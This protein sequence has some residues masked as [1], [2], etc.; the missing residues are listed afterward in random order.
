[1]M[2]YSISLSLQLLAVVIWMVAAPNNAVTSFCFVP[3]THGSHFTSRTSIKAGGDQD[4]PD[5]VAK[6]IIVTGD[7]QGGYYRSCV[8]NE[9]SFYIQN[10][11]CFSI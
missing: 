2:K 6:R 10:C 9:V 1:M 4:E 3:T 7:V 8:L 11:K 5:I